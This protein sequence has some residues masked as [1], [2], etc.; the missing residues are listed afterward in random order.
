MAGH[1]GVGSSSRRERTGWY[2]YDWA[3]SA[4]QTTL[5]AVF[6]GPFLTSI[7]KQA[8]GC[9]LGADTCT[10]QVHPL[11]IPVTAGSYYPYLVSLSV[12]L[13]V[14]VLP[15]MGALSDRAPRKKPLLAGAAFIGA[16]ATIAMV[17]VTGQRYLLGGVL[18]LIGNIAFGA[19]IVIYNS[20]LPGLA[21]PDERDKVSSRGWAVGYLGGGLLLALNLVAVTMYRLMAL[22]NSGARSKASARTH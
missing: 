21:G 12:L 19:S 11:G 2:F 13:S 9:T 15:V 14:F 18:F 8:A 10:G 4:F 6:L 22:S 20:F 7:A 5:I 3:N 16:A 1:E 17:F